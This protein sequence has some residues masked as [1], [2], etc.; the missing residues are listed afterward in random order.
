MIKTVVDYM[1]K[2]CEL[3]PDV[4][5]NKIQATLIHSQNNMLK[6][7][8]NRGGIF[9]SKRGKDNRHYMIINSLQAYSVKKKMQRWI[10][11]M[12]QKIRNRYK[13]YERKWD[14]YYYFA[15]ND[16]KFAK[17]VSQKFG[18]RKDYVFENIKLYKM[19]EE[20]LLHEQLKNYIFRVP[21]VVDCG[22]TIWK[23]TYKSRDFEYIY[24]MENDGL[25]PVKKLD[26]PCHNDLFEKKMFNFA[27]LKYLEADKIKKTI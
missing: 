4:P 20:C 8:K 3:Y 7:L 12:H 11:R 14:G 15:L 27:W 6:Y 18:N 21:M 25:V 23:E 24:K 26:K 16:L 2:M 17:V 5:R 1:D 19:F 22:W 13:R 10:K 9:L